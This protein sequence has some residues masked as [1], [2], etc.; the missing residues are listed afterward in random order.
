MNERS[1]TSTG[2]LQPNTG[3]IPSQTNATEPICVNLELAVSGRHLQK[4]LQLGLGR[5]Y[6][7]YFPTLQNICRLVYTNSENHHQDVTCD[8]YDRPTRNLWVYIRRSRDLFLRTYRHLH[9]CSKE[10]ESSVLSRHRVVEVPV[11]VFTAVNANSDYH[12]ECSS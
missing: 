2:P 11:R 5:C 6:V 8:D 9:G 1:V 12:F 3:T 4:S 7:K 10:C